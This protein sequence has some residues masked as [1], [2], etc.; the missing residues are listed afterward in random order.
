MVE[1]GNGLDSSRKVLLEIRGEIRDVTGTYLG[2]RQR[3]SYLERLKQ[4][5][6][7]RRRPRKNQVRR[8]WPGR[9]AHNPPN[10][11]RF[12]HL[13][14]DLPDFLATPSAIPEHHTS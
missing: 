12:L 6:W 9:I 1:E 2:P 13:A 7:Q 5:R 10:P 14:P 8:P 3:R 4:A 11:P